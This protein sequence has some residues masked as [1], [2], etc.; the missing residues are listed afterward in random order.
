[1]VQGK[2]SAGLVDGDDEQIIDCLEHVRDVF[3]TITRFLIVSG[4][5]GSHFDEGL[6]E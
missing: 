1:M 2:P 3:W 4:C 6:H 5:A